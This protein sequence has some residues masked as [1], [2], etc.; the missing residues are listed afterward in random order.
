M[1][2]IGWVQA[3]NKSWTYWGILHKCAVT[4]FFQDKRNFLRNPP[5][6]VQFH[7]DY[8]VS[9]PIAAV[10]L[11]EDPNLETMRFE[12]VPKQWAQRDVLNPSGAETGIFQ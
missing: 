11:Q 3:Y 2:L 10:M 7:F 4:F 1:S 12:L 8:S 5:A 9:A 6:G